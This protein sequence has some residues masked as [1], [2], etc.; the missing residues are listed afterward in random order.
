MVASSRSS[1]AARR[2]R[3]PSHRAALPINWHSS[4]D[5]GCI[6]NELSKVEWRVALIV[7][8]CNCLACSIFTAFVILD[9]LIFVLPQPS[10]KICSVTLK[11]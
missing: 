5:G 7:R 4:T 6:S 1:A 3:G 9:I 2:R 11:S 8:P 10:Y